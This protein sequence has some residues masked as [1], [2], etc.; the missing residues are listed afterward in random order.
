MATPK[1]CK[2]PACNCPVKEGESYCSTACKDAGDTT[3][4]VC[5]CNHPTCQGEALRG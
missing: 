5:Q 2:H 4:L 3:E 1:T